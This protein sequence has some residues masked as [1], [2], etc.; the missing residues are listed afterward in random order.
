MKIYYKIK[1][2]NSNDIYYHLISCDADFV[3]PL[4]KK[5][6]L[7]EY[8][9][10]LFDKSV[11]FEAWYQSNLV[12]LIACY[13]NESN[14]FITNVSALKQYSGKGIASTLMQNCIDYSKQKKCSQIKLEV[15][16]LNSS[17]IHLYNKFG[18]TIFEK[19]DD[20]LL[21]KLEL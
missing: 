8:S 11:T 17:A 21:M 16:S 4:S 2:A 7:L 1:S 9:Q 6:N 12:G 18:F 20:S 13:Y 14:A 3:P 19:K 5:V 15:N 10:K